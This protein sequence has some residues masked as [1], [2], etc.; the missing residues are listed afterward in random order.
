MKNYIEGL[1]RVNGGGDIQHAQKVIEAYYETTTFYG[2]PETIE[3]VGEHAEERLKNL[4]ERFND[5]V[6]FLQL[7]NTEEQNK[8]YA[9][10]YKSDYIKFDNLLDASYCIEWTKNHQPKIKV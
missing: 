4:F 3:E 5:D 8:H 7:K 9:K 1:K 2:C 10:Y 6:K